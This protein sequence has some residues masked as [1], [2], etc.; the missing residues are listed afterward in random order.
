MLTILVSYMNRVS[1]SLFYYSFNCFLFHYLLLLLDAHDTSVVHEQGSN[2]GSCL[3]LQCDTTNGTTS[4]TT[5][6]TC[7]VVQLLE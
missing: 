7:A 2:N 3:E 6:A 4:S 1:V 5:T